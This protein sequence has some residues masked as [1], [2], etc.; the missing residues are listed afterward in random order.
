MRKILMLVHHCL[1]LLGW[2]PFYSKQAEI[3]SLLHP[4]VQCDQS[5]VWHHEYDLRFKTALLPVN[6]PQLDQ[7]APAAAPTTF[8]EL[9]EILDS[10]S[11]QSHCREKCHQQK[12]AILY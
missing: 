11:R 3:W 2:L 1:Y 6:E 9:M 7:F 12:V 10:V 8:G 5:F 4:E